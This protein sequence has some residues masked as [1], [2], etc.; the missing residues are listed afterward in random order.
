MLPRVLLIGGAPM[1]GKTT[2]ARILGRRHGRSVISTDDLGVAV[3]AALRGR[4]PMIA[5]DHREYF[6]SRTVDQLWNEELERLQSLQVPIDAVARLHANDWS[7][8]A[9]LEGWA[10][11]PSA[12]DEPTAGVCVWL[13]ATKEMLEARIRAD[14]AFWSGARDEEQMIQ[15]FVERSLRLE[16]YLNDAAQKRPLRMLEVTTELTPESI[17]DRVEKLFDGA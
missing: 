15:K 8:P 11:L 5:E 10:I 2:V 4:R 1:V 6:L 3:H 13:I 14:Q 17:A 9:I 12:F 16:A 7:V